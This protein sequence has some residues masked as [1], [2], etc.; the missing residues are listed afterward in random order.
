MDAASGRTFETLNPASEKVLASVAHGEAEDVN[1]A[2]GAARAAFADGSRAPRGVRTVV[3]VDD[4][5][6]T[7]TYDPIIVLTRIG[8][9]NRPPS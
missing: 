2:V 4:G 6:G 9:A 7:D 1:R 8:P 3:V 5:A